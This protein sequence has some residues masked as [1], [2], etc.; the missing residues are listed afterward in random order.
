[1]PRGNFLRAMRVCGLMSGTSLDGLDMAIVDFSMTNGVLEHELKHFTTMPYTPEL[2]EQLASLMDQKAPVQSISSMNMYLGELYALSIK[3]IL[4]N[5]QITFDSI[6]LVS[7]HGQT[8]WHEP[9]AGGDA[10]SRPNTLQLGDI[11]VIAEHT[12]K[13]V[14]GDFRTRD[15]AAG[16][17]GAPLVPFADQLLFQSEQSG[18][19]LVN[20][21]GISNITVLPPKGSV[22]EIIAY[23]TGPGNMI[24]DVFSS[25]YTNGKENFDQD[26]RFAGAGKVSEDWLNQLL[27]H[28]YYKKPAPKSTGREEFGIGYAESIWH[29]ADLLGLSSL[30][31][32]AT[33]TMLTARTLADEIQKYVTSHELSEIFV[34]GGGVHNVTLL[35]YLRELLHDSVNVEKIEMLGINSDAKEAFVF[36]LLGYLGFH[37]LPNNSPA[38]T[39]A[40]RQTVL[41]K[42]AW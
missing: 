11:S 21:G 10:F 38:A 24:V 4:A 42:I 22:Q 9:I 23:D 29:K 1:M 26:G 34:S 25:I 20:I 31:K 32:I 3:E 40:N 39:G 13:P 30:D 6:D 35:N 16:G 36:A 33:A 7:S 17:Q 27:Q 28:S 2:K 18:R 41:G 19:V 37:Q 14:I 15:M 12:G 8:I 5:S